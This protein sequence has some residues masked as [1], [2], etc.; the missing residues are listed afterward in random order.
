MA[1]NKNNK[2]KNNN[3]KGPNP[4]S[5]RKVMQDIDKRKKEQ[6]RQLRE[7]GITRGGKS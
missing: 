5:L 6:E 2:K 7:L 4:F 3:G 1:N